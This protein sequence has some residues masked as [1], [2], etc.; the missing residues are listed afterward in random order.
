MQLSTLSFKVLFECYTKYIE[1]ETIHVH[2][3]TCFTD[4]RNENIHL[5]KNVALKTEYYTRWLVK[6]PFDY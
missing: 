3:N 1:D 2:L 6:V 4:D 5:R